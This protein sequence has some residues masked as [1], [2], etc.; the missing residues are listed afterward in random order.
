MVLVEW[1]D[2]RLPTARWQFMEDY[3]IPSICDCLSIG[4]LIEKNKTQLVLASHLGDWDNEDK[5]IAGVTVIPTCSVRKIT[6]LNDNKK[7]I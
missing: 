2:S 5:Q 6:I 3:I 1:V 7:G 4:F